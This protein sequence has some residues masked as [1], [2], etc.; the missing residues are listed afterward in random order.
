MSNTELKVWID[1]DLCTGSGLCETT[2]PEVFVLQDDGFPYV[3]DSLR[4]NTHSDNTEYPSG[5]ADIPKELEEK[6]IEASED[7]PGECIFIECSLM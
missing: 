3:V 6:V 5:L 4:Y 1:Q 2:V 7:C